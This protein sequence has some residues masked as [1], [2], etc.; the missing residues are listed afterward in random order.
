MDDFYQGFS[1]PPIE[2][3]SSDHRLGLRIAL[4]GMVGLILIL[5]VRTVFT[6]GF[7]RIFVQEGSA[8][9]L[10]NIFYVFMT[11][12]ALTMVTTALGVFIASKAFPSGGNRDMARVV[13]LAIVLEIAFGVGMAAVRSMVTEGSGGPSSLD[14]MIFF[15]FAWM[16][17]ATV[18]P[19]LMMAALDS[20]HRG[21]ARPALLVM[22]G[23][24]STL[25]AWTFFVFDRVWEFDP[26]TFNLIIMFT[27]VAE[28][29][30]LLLLVIFGLWPALNAEARAVTSSASIQESTRSSGGFKGVGNTLVGVLFII[31]AASGEIVLRG[32]DSS[33]AIGFIGAVLILIGAVQFI[34]HH[35]RG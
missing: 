6:V 26:E 17:L 15:N 9:L 35:S 12:N 22:V 7:S 32:T 33:L 23:I 28:L 31:G 24:A 10:K 30:K 14:L 29:A 4:F 3:Q 8:S 27:T 1:D 34:T 16:M 18:W 20:F 19:V 25:S 2:E 5:L 21:R 13:S 11:L